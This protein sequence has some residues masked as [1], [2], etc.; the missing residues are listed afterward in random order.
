MNHF[1][2]H[3]KGIA[4][5][6]M[7]IIICEFLLSGCYSVRSSEVVRNN[8][9]SGSG[10]PTGEMK[11]SYK[12]SNEPTINDPDVKLDIYK[13]E[14]SLVKIQNYE[15]QSI[16]PNAFSK[17]V[18]ITLL[19]GLVAG[20]AL[21]GK[22]NIGESESSG[23]LTGAAIGL[24]VGLVIAWPIS[25]KMGKKNERYRYV[26]GPTKEILS[27]PVLVRDKLI[28]VSSTEKSVTKKTSDYGLFIFSP[29]DDFNNT[30]SRNNY[31]VHF[32]LQK[33]AHF[34]DKALDLKPSLWLNKVAK[35]TADNA[36]IYSNSSYGSVLSATR[37]DF[38]Y[39]I[40]SDSYTSKRYKIRLLD[41]SFGWINKRDAFV[42]YSGSIGSD[43][44]SSIKNYI[45]EK[46]RNWQLQGGF[47]STSAY[48]RRM[49]SRDLKINEITREAMNLF[50]EDYSRLIHWDE[51]TISRY[52]P[53]NETFTI[54]ICDLEPIVVHVPIYSAKDFKTKWSSNK[55]TE[56][57]FM[58]VDGNWKL[59]G[60]KIVVQDVAYEVKYQSDLSYSY[61][62]V[63]QFPLD[64]SPISIPQTAPLKPYNDL[65]QI[66]YDIRT[67]LPKTRM[68]NPDGVAS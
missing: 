39:K 68:R 41:H 47:E 3:Q 30:Y 54:K 51:V 38:E 11:Y 46:I 26:P 4:W 9:I 57:T 50:Q 24:G 19:T 27:S 20:G 23:A 49:V 65:D 31:P 8:V 40:L 64:L 53:N 32:R 37:K 63:N 13:S 35:I 61:N 15:K 22:N 62:P 12:V 59:A 66:T 52:D 45:E 67:N 33:G 56:P 60:V 17:I 36:I 43:I 28:T 55:I 2:R 44:S 16:K 42:Y 18:L 7:L 25:R 48:R 10:K 5:V 14:Y 6:L 1:I 29:K 58:L 21:I 34:F